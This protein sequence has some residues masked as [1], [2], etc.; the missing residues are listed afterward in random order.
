MKYV[1]GK[2]QRDKQLIEAVVRSY[3]PISR[4]GI[5][6][7]TELR[8]SAM[9]GLV[10][11]LIDEGRLVEAGSTSSRTSI[12][13][14]QILLRLNERYRYVAAV[15]F[16]EDSVRSGLF[17]LHPSPVQTHTESAYILAGRDGLV[18]Q[19]IS[20]VHGILKRTGVSADALIGIGI[21]DPGLVDRRRG[22]AVTSSTL[23]FWRDVPLKHI[24]EQEF[25]VATTL[26]T[27]TRA[28]AVAER[29]RGA[30][31]MREN[32]I[33]VDYGAGI[34]A[35][36]ITQGQSL[37]GENGAAGEFGHIHIDDDGP[38]CKCGSYG[39]LEAV[40][41]ARA[42]ESKVR[43]AILDGA[44]S[45]VQRLADN[46]PERITAEMILEASA[47]GDKIASHVV[48]DAGLQLG[49]GIA[50]LVNLFNPAIVVLDRRLALAGQEML[51][52]IVRVV[53]RQALTTSSADCDVRFAR[54]G[55]EAGM[56]GAA[57][58]ILEEHFEIPVLKPARFE[59]EPEGLALSAP[60][61]VDEPASGPSVL[62]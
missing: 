53:R 19:L 55:D 42:I 8:R 61:G 25:G 18:R 10:R 56:L 35:G 2:P 30:G 52:R 6:E 39:C 36:V 41:G 31:E 13:R 40:A 22:V 21:A 5:H 23:E 57:L 43:K 49:R 27:K 26:E 46:D 50:N 58:L 54:I 1:T 15:E 32:M 9:S 29:M 24:F 45:E 48:A 20:A 3:G 12:G 62:A 33:Y 11:E 37:Y 47:S 44:V 60:S 16:D 59:V 34:G 17:D 4:E 38:A 7:L 28:K 51:D 14:R